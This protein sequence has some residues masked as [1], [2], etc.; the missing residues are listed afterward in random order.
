MVN[1]D[2]A[3]YNKVPTYSDPAFLAGRLSSKDEVIKTKDEVLAEKEARRQEAEEKAKFL[4]R[5]NEKLMDIIKDSLGE[6]KA[7]SK[8]G[9]MFLESIATELR[10]EHGVMM[11]SQDRLEGNQPGT[12]Q[13]ESHKKE[14]DFVKK[15]QKM[16]SKNAVRK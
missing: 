9:L 5:Q 4:E 14:H 11:D 3:I 8:T 6:L 12:L 13:K 1:E 2:P 15:R 10:V 7:N 16:G